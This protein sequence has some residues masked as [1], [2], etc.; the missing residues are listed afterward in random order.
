M[1]QKIPERMVMTRIIK[2][3]PATYNHFHSAWE[4]TAD[5]R[6][7]LIQLRNRLMTE[8]KRLKAQDEQAE[9]AF[10]AK[11]YGNWRKSKESKPKRMRRCYICNET[12]HLKRDCPLRDKAK[13]KTSSALVCEAL[14][15]VS[16]NSWYL[17]SGA[18]EHMTNRFE[19]L[20]DYRILKKKRPVTI[21]NGE[22]VFGVGPTLL[23]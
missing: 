20:Y 13:Q 17:D 2:I 1:G 19:W 15:A 6:K 12:T 22:H 11:N 10:V 21:E 23:V 4:S 16:E 3:F 9:G 14:S 7:T 5:D 8:E 18:T